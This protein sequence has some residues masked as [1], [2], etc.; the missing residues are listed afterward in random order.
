MGNITIPLVEESETG[1]GTKIENEIDSRE[2]G[3]ESAIVTVID[4]IG[5]EKK[6]ARGKEN[7]RRKE[8]VRRSA[9]ERKKERRSARERRIVIVEIEIPMI[10]SERGEIATETGNSKIESET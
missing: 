4:W 9:F 8:S 10:G 7:A 2:N 6:I 1:I 5:K 3:T